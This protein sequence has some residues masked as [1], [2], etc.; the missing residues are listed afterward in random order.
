MPPVGTRKHNIP[1]RF[2][3]LLLDCELASSPRL[4]ISKKARNLEWQLQQIESNAPPPP[5]P[6]TS[7]GV[8]Q[9][10]QERQS[11]QLA[12]GC[13]YV[14]CYPTMT[15]TTELLLPHHL[16]P[17]HPQPQQTPAWRVSIWIQ[18]L[19]WCHSKARFVAPL[20]GTGN[21]PHPHTPCQSMLTAAS[22]HSNGQQCRSPLILH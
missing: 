8:F 18:T 20:L 16:L 7:R 2:A 4:S 11:S 6:S 5:R 13:V 19:S 1:A 3:D 9:K 21:K 17:T 10:H 14:G 22:G 15:T 12:E